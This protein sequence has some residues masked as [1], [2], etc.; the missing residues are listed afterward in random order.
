MSAENLGLGKP[1]TTPQ[2]RD[3]IHVAVVPVRANERLYPAQAVG[4]LNGE[5]AFSGGPHVGIVDPFLTHPVVEGDTFW[6]FLFPGTVQ[7][8]RHEW[9]HPAFPAQAPPVTAADVPDKVASELWLRGYA[10]NVSPYDDAETAYTNLLA[11]LR[12]GE[13][14]YH[15]MD[16][17]QRGDV[18][19][20]EGL[21]HHAEV[22]LGIKIDFGTFSFSCSC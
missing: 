17:H 19:D 1:I 16:L 15:G 21:K 22:V 18:D 13:L 10:K 20:E 3:A 7:S 2:Q 8:I 9:T 12:R 11:G 4:V 5:R 6:L 14:F